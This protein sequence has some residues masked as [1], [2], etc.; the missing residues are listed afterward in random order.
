MLPLDILVVA[1]H[2]DDAEISVGG[3]IAV[4]LQQNLR[5]GVVELTSGEPTPHG[6]LETRRRET[7]TVNTRFWGSAGEEV[8][9]FRTGACRR[10][11]R[12]GGSWRRFF[13]RSDRRSSWHHT[14]R[15]HIPIMLLQAVSVM[16]LASGPNSVAPIWLATHSGHH[17]CCIIS[18]FICGF[19]QHRRL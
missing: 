2:P 4:S 7:A 16:T 17:S 15:M 13:E 18:A 9:I 19:I 1:P 10:I 11:L 14:G 8:W 3:T 5:V 12:R 6:S